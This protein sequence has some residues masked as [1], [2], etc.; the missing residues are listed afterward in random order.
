MMNI[1]QKL[2]SSTNRRVSPQPEDPSPP[3]SEEH[4]PLRARSVNRIDDSDKVNP[5]KLAKC[6]KNLW[7][8]SHLL[9]S[10]RIELTMLYHRRDAA[11]EYRKA[12]LY[13]QRSI[14]RSKLAETVKLYDE[15]RTGE[16]NPPPST[17]RLPV[18]DLSASPTQIPSTQTRVCGT[19]E[20]LPI[21]K[22]KEDI[23]RRVGRSRISV[24]GGETGC[25]KSSRLPVMLLED[26]ESRGIPCRIMVRI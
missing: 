8:R 20:V 1:V 12:E 21:D 2:K 3:R 25:G 4:S 26:A 22:Y 15:L 7:K 10:I 9:G 13:R 6:R 16:T 23:L 17:R 14:T 18:I 11:S 5:W 24:I 19:T